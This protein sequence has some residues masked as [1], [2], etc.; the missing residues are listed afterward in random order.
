M[1][2]GKRLFTLEIFPGLCRQ[3]RGEDRLPSQRERCNCGPN[4][5]LQRQLDDCRAE[6]RNALDVR[7]SIQHAAQD[8]KKELEDLQPTLAGRST[9]I[10]KM[11]AGDSTFYEHVEF[12]YKWLRRFDS[13]DVPNLITAILRKLSRD[14]QEE[15][16]SDFCYR[17]LMTNGMKHARDALLLDRD[18]QNSEHLTKNVYTG[19]HF[20][21]LR[22]VGKV[23]KRVCS[24]I[25]QS[26]KWE[27]Q[28]DGTKTRQTMHPNSSVPAPSIFSLR[29]INV[30]EE[31]AEKETNLHV[32]GAQRRQCRRN[33]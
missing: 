22:L 20:S 30:A 1:C 7:N 10:A 25:E 33:P 13:A 4:A 12:G 3:A 9:T 32:H 14:R 23:S 31:R 8:V 15:D 29:A 27:H 18:K 21:V 2:F 28:E 26:L 5:E 19:D 24:L 17:T 11:A 16:G 6:L